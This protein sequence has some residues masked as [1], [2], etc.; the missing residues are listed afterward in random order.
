MQQLENPGSM[1]CLKRLASAAVLSD[2]L[3]PEILQPELL[4]ELVQPELAGLLQLP[5][6]LL[7][8]WFRLKL[9]D[10]PWQIDLPPVLIA[11]VSLSARQTVR[12]LAVHR[13]RLL[14]L[15]Q[16]SLELSGVAHRL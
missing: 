8:Y 4:Y 7:E 3:Q 15:A 9:R 12:T 2:P 5:H 6:L 1:D 13:P 11:A 14:L 16:Y 10:R